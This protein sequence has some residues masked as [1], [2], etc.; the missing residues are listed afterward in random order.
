MEIGL[1]LRQAMLLN[2]I[3]YNCEAWHNIS[4]EE[5]KILEKVDEH[6]LRCLVRAHS[7]VPLEF[8]Y[9]EAGAI[10]VRFLISCRRILYFQTI[11][12]RPE[13][14]LTRRVL[15]AQQQ[16]VLPGDFIQLVQEDLKLLRSDI[17]ESYILKTSKKSFKTEVKKKI[18][19]AAFEYLKNI[20]KTHS[21]ICNIN[22]TEFKTQN[23]MTS[24]IFTNI[25]VNILHALRSKMVNVKM[26]FKSKYSDLSCPICLKHED[27]QPHVL[28]CDVLNSRIISNEASRN[29][30]EY[31]DIFKEVFKQKEITNLYQRLLSI[32]SEEEN[33]N[34]SRQAAP[35]T[36]G[37]VLE[38]N[39]N[40]PT[41]IVHYFS[42][43]QK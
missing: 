32:R 7:K 42:G 20:Q 34:T 43:K 41:S 14:E 30:I 12:K 22:Y 1:H 5:V 26:N 25:E 4:E 18:H 8:L 11:L 6:L 37:G 38:N 10:P 15:K 9:L 35:S 24:P 21:K 3:L 23:Y 36:S 28:K 27:D 33:N 17:D 40:I 29:K 13:N 2:G 31:D 19:Q 16:D 39:D